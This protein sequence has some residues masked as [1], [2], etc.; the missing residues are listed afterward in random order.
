MLLVIAESADRLRAL[1]KTGYYLFADSGAVYE[2]VECNVEGD[3]ATGYAISRH[4]P[5]LRFVQ[6]GYATV[7]GKAMKR[8]RITVARDPGYANDAVIFDDQC[9][10]FGA[11]MPA[12]IAVAVDSRPRRRQ[13][14][15]T[16]VELTEMADRYR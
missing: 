9:E 1:R 14:A 13:L 12:R 11:L 3:V 5:L 8:C 10:S 6:T 4:G 7:P 15:Q 16:L 2:V